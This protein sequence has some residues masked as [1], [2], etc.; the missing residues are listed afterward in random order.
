MP[1]TAK[2][3]IVIVLFLTL[4]IALV[5]NGAMKVRS[6]SARGAAGGYV[7]VMRI[8]SGI[9]SILFALF[10]TYLSVSDLARSHP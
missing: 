10:L 7:V 2:S 3:L 4:G 8:S 6:Q 5:W 9:A 1:D